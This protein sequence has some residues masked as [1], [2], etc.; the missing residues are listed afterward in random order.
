MNTIEQMIHNLCPEGVKRVPLW[1]VTAWDKKFNGVDKDKQPIVKT[2]P[3]LL[4]KDMQALEVENGNVM[5]LSTGNYVGYTTEEL[6]GKNLCEGEVVTMPWGGTAKGIKYYRGKFVTA[7]NRIATSTDTK[8]L[9]NKYFYYWFINNSDLINTFYRGAGIQHPSMVDVLNME[10]PLPPLEIQGEIV[11]ILDRFAVLTAELE[12]ELEAR[13]KQYEYYRTRLLSFDS[14]S[15]TVQWRALGEVGTFF[16]GLTG[17]NKADFNNGNAAFITYMN[18]Y[19]NIAVNIHPTER[20]RI[21]AGENQNTLLWGDILF[22]GSSETPDECG[23]SSV[24]TQE[25]EEPL[26]LNSFCFGYRFYDNMLFLPKYIKHWMRS[27]YMR[28]A[29]GKTANGVTRFNVSKKEMAKIKIPIIPL[30]EQER[31]A[32]I[33]DKFDQL[34]NGVKDSIPELIDS[35]Q[36]QYE[37]YRNKLLTFPEA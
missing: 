31:I 23:I 13:R 11:K 10:I 28:K 34:V 2:Y 25:P 15:D 4:A 16:G 8:V 30:E 3:Y 6:A 14:D 21:D 19:K 18:I 32:F 26:Y 12:A 9:N 36:K 20:V 27:G 5:L 35:V 17:K 7:D 24:V 29:I 33:L 22:T 37:Y 1:S